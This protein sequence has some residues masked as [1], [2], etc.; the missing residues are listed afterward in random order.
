MWDTPMLNIRRDKIPP[1]ALA[2]ANNT[3]SVVNTHF[4]SIEP[5]EQ[6]V[7]LKLS[8]LQVRYLVNP[9][10]L[11]TSKVLLPVQSLVQFTSYFRIRHAT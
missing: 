11:C 10:V 4:F 9:S 5:Y 1:C 6:C 3:I 7:V 8:F 2:L